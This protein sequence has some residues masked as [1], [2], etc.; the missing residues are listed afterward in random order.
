MKN[1]IDFL[2]LLLSDKIKA[3]GMELLGKLINKLVENGEMEKI[4]LVSTDSEYRKEMFKV[5]GIE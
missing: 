2:G 1:I 4:K 5:Y 3:E